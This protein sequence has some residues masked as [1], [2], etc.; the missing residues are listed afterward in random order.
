MGLIRKELIGTCLEYSFM[1]YRGAEIQ[2]HLLDTDVELGS[3]VNEL[4]KWTEVPPLGTAGT[5][6]N[7][8]F[9]HPM[10]MSTDSIIDGSVE[11]TIVVGLDAISAPVASYVRLTEVSMGLKLVLADD[12]LEDVIPT[13]PIWTGAKNVFGLGTGLSTTVN[14]GF[15]FSEMVYSHPVPAG[16]RLVMN[17]VLTGYKST[18]STHQVTLYCGT[19]TKDIQMS[20]PMVE[21]E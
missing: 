15:Y 13:A 9:V 4:Y 11:G 21:E 16:A 3:K 18:S 7:R 1:S 8:N 17:I 6:T 10:P 12:T 2:T 20:I 14:F 19:A 5:I